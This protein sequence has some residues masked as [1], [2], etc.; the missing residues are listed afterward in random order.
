MYVRQSVWVDQQSPSL[1]PR[2]ACRNVWDRVYFAAVEPLLR[3]ITGEGR[4]G[5]VQVDQTN[6]V[7][8]SDFEA[9]ACRSIHVRREMGQ[10][11]T[12][13]FSRLVRGLP[14]LESSGGAGGFA[15]SD[16]GFWRTFST[17]GSRIDDGPA[18]F[19]EGNVK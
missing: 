18:V 16:A 1:P 8:P 14:D 9:F 4:L 5:L 13:F 17:S 6:Q 15:G 12:S 2:H 10:G 7:L 11:Q 3:D 19:S